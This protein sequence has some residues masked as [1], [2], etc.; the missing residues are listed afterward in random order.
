MSER[1]AT[2][3]TVIYHMLPRGC[4]DAQP[5]DAPYRA[6]TLATEGFIHCTAEPELLAGVANRFYRNDPGDWLIL[7]VDPAALVSAACAGRPPMDTCFPIFMA[8]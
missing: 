2:Q 1:T 6:D 7:V 5:P 3:P 4:W 8:H